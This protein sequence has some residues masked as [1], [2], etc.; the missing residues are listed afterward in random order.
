MG[1]YKMIGQPLLP[2]KVLEGR[3]PGEEFTAKLDS[4]TESRLVG[5]GALVILPDKKEE[6]ATKTEQKQERPEPR[7]EPQR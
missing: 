6:P 3:V 7:K 2:F 5:A 4:L 1:R